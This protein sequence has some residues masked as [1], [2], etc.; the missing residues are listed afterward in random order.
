MRLIFAKKETL[1]LHRIG[2]PSSLTRDCLNFTNELAMNSYWLMLQ[3][4]LAS[5]TWYESNLPNFMSFIY[6][7]PVKYV[8]F[9]A[10]P[11][12][13][14]PVQH[15]LFWTKKC[16]PSPRHAQCERGQNLD[17][18]P[19]VSIWWNTERLVGRPYLDGV[20]REVSKWLGLCS[21]KKLGRN[22]GVHDSTWWFFFGTEV[23]MDQRW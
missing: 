22:G 3:R 21:N 9:W 8:E 23:R 11:T 13:P 6:L 5:T 17:A 2:Q 1:R 14:H 4:S 16:H 10:I 12:W 19:L 20:S 15:G 18:M 7:K